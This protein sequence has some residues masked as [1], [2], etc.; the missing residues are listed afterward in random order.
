MLLRSC[1]CHAAP[2][3]PTAPPTAP[4]DNEAPQCV[5]CM[6]E[7]EPDKIVTLRCMHSFHGQC[8]CNHLVHDGRCPIC[9][10]SPYGSGNP[11]AASVY[12]S[13]EEEDWMARGPTLKDA[14]KT[15]KEA[16]KNGD[17]RTAK[18]LSTYRKW[19]SDA[20]T[21]RKEMKELRTTLRPLED[22]IDDKIEAFEKKERA[23]F[24]AKNKRVIDSFDAACKEI[25]KCRTHER[26]AKLRIAKKH[27]FVR[28]SRSMRRSATWT[29]EEVA[30]T[31]EE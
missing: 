7:I 21:A 5:I 25:T 20:T 22:A 30:D 27:G 18:M 10:D 31:M 28:R 29:A 4:T 14:F 1:P 24:D 12:S 19:K 11:D 16:A 2:T 15:G 17:K 3:A 23:K 26:N 6:E 13:D 9:R 8:I